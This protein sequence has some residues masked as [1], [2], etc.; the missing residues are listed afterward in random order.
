MTANF[1]ADY[2]R[3]IPAQYAAMPMVNAVGNQI[4]A[5]YV[6]KNENQNRSWNISGALSKALSHGFA[7]RG[8]GEKQAHGE[9]GL[10][11]FV[12]EGHGHATVGRAGDR[13]ASELQ[14]EGHLGVLGEDGVDVGQ[15]GELDG[16]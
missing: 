15:V 11:L 9:L 1:G 4:T 7:F 2:R 3:R 10:A 12:G 5:N 8:R 16:R 14:L 13:R 6:I